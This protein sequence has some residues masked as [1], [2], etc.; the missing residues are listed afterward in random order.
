MALSGSGQNL[1]SAITG[2]DYSNLNS[3]YGYN[4]SSSGENYSDS[5]SNY[6]SVNP[7]YKDTVKNTAPVADYD[8]YANGVPQSIIDAENEINNK[9][10]PN[11]DYAKQVQDT[12]IQD[13]LGYLSDPNYK[14]TYTALQASQAFEYLSE[15]NKGAN[16]AN[17]ATPPAD[18]QLFTEIVPLWDAARNI[19][20]K[21]VE[22]Q[23]SPLPTEE[24]SIVQRAYNNQNLNATQRDILD[25][26]QIEHGD[27][28]LLNFWDKAKALLVPSS[29]IEETMDNAPSWAKYIQNIFPSIMAGG[30]G[31]AVG[32]IFGPAGAAIGGGVVGGL[33]Y[34]QGVTNVE[35]PVI[36][37]LLEGMDILSVW[38]E[39]GQGAI[40][41][42]AKGA[43]DK[44]MEDGQF[45]LLE[46]GK[47][48]GN[49]LQEFPDLWEV[50][51]FSYEIGAD[52]GFDNLLNTGRNVVAGA[53]DALFGTELGQRDINTV[54]RA[55]LGIG[56]LIDVDP[57]SRGYDALLN[58]YLPVYR[59]LRDEAVN[60]GMTYDQAKEFSLGH[61]SELL[62][63][64]MG[65]T[66]LANDFAVS[67]V[68]DPLNLAPFIQAKAAEFIGNKTGDT[69][70]S[71]AAKAALKNSSP[72]VDA[73]SVPVIQPIVEFVTG[74]NATQGMDTI[75]RVWAQEL[76]TKP[77]DTLSGFQRRIA[78]IDD[79]GLIKN[80]NQETN[81]LKRFFGQTEESKMYQISENTVS[82]LGSLLFDTDADPA[83]IPE[84]MREFA[85]LSEIPDDSPLAQ[86]RNSGLLNTMQ[87]TFSEITF[88]DIDKIQKGIDTYRQFASN[89]TAVDTVAQKLNMSIDDIFDA[90]DDTDK[91]S[92]LYLK[93]INE[94][95]TYMDG[96][97]LVWS[98][99]QVC[100][101]IDVFSSDQL[102]RRQY[103]LTMLKADIMEMFNKKSDDALFKRY[104]IEPDM[105]YNRLGELTKSV[106][107]IAL[108]NFSPSYFVNN[109]LN[110]LITR[111]VTG[112][113][114]V[115]SDEVK[116]ANAKRGLFYSREG[117]P[118]YEKT[119]DRITS[120]KHKDDIIGKAQ[121][122]WSNL[123]SEEKLSGKILKGLSNIDIEST[124]TRNAFEIGA[125]R[126]WSATWQPGLNI[127]EIPLELQALGITPE[128]NNTIYKAA[129]DSNSYSEFRQKLMG[130]VILP[131]AMSTL[132]DTISKRY[133]DK[134]G[135]LTRNLVDSNPW[136]T[137]RVS[138]LLETGNPDVIRSGFDDIIQEFTN[139]V[140]LQNIAQLETQFEDLCNRFAS[141]GLSAV[142]EMRQ[143][144]DDLYGDIWIDQTKESADLF[145]KRVTEGLW[146]EEE[147]RPLYESRMTMNNA[148]YQM[149]RKYE[150]QYLAAM[151]TGLGLTDD[152]AKNLVIDKLKQ[153]DIE[154]QYIN[155][156]HQLFMK[157]A[158]KNSPDYDYEY[159]KNSKL[160]MLQKVLDGKLEAAKD[161]DAIIVQHLR[162]T[163]SFTY[164]TQ[165][166]EF[167]SRLQ[168]IQRKKAELNQRE[169]NWLSDRLNNS[170]RIEVE[171]IEY[172]NSALRQIYKNDI[173]IAQREA[174]AMLS[175]LEDG[176]V[177]KIDEKIKLDVAQTLGI[178]L[179]YR[180]AKTDVDNYSDFL[181][182]YT[183]KSDPNTVL[184]KADFSNTTM[185]GTFVE[186]AA[187][188][189]DPQTLEELKKRYNDGDAVPLGA[190]DVKNET[191]PGE[192]VGTEYTAA[193]SE[194]IG[195]EYSPVKPNFDQSEAKLSMVRTQPFYYDTHLVKAGVYNEEK[196]IA[197]ITSDM[198]DT[199][200]TSGYTFPVIGIDVENPE[201][202]WV[203]VKDEPI[204]VTPGQPN[205][206]VYSM[207]AQN[208]EHPMRYGTTPATEPWGMAAW[209]TSLPLRELL[210]YWKDESL[211][212][213][214][215]STQN[216]SFFGNLTPEQQDAVYKWADSKLNPA[217]NYQRFASQRYGN[218]MVDLSLLN[219]NDRRGFDSTLTTIMPYQYWI[220]R[221]VM[222]WGARMIDQPKWF[223]MYARLEKEIEKNKRDFLPTRLEGMIG[224][225]LPYMPEGLG[226]GLFFNPFDIALPQK[227]FY[228]MTEY[229]DRNLHTIHENTISIID[230][231]YKNAKPYNGHII[232]K[233]E[234]DEAMK[235]SGDL[236]NQ[237]FTDQR[238][239]DETNTGLS[240]LVGSLINPNVLISSAWKALETKNGKDISYSPM[241]KMGNTLRA[242]ARD[243]AM[244]GVFGLMA[245]ALQLPEKT[246]RSMLGVESDPIGS[247][248]ADYW[249][250]KY[251]SDML[252]TKEH[253]HNEVYNAIAERD[254]N[255]LW[256]EARDRYSTSEAYKQQGGA[257]LNEIMQS[258][259]GNKPTSFGNMAGT[260]IASLFGGRTYSS[261]EEDYRRMQDLYRQIKDDP[262]MYS[263]FWNQLPDYKAGGYAY[264][265]NPTEMLHTILVDNCNNA[266]YALPETQK[267]AVREAFGGQFKE[268]FLNRSTDNIPDKTLI[269]WTRAMEGNVPNI[270]NDAIYQPM[271]QAFQVQWYA[272]STQ[273]LYDRYLNEKKQR[274]P[275]IDT[276]EQGY[277]SSAIQ[278]QYKALHPELQ[279]YWDW[280]ESIGMANPA[281]GT[282]LKRH[283]ANNSVASGKYDSITEAVKAQV[284]N[285]TR[286][287]LKNH[288]EK[289]WSMPPSAEHQLKIAYT[290]L[291]ISIP[292]ET[293]IKEIKW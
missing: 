96:S 64:Y 187:K 274:F 195:T 38:F 170:D 240:G 275:G 3:N 79:N 181:N 109:W 59:A 70:L 133:D 92:Q 119:G 125:N 50:G 89:R 268:L 127:P 179:L 68:A 156:E 87:S 97:G 265:D 113:G 58:T 162:D 135:K 281:L 28:R 292:Y 239:S 271:Q 57:N 69:A 177:W 86:Y 258:M 123:T 14:G 139:N 146:N 202:V 293:W 152:V 66:G 153:F 215:K 72:I 24:Q 284:N 145:R 253:T 9:S 98:P 214:Y 84:L 131:G 246:W 251:L 263:E 196:L 111:S 237:I 279:Q 259:A 126:Y 22:Q 210:N 94:N 105:W 288:I 183:D 193:N 277:Y 7:N 166:N 266:Y 120:K 128:M 73:L 25:A 4:S 216:G 149:A 201:A 155:E 168:D 42:T 225:P 218:T 138:S 147:F 27:W 10:I 176:R 81:P 256:Q 260:A 163:L 164:E 29:N 198:P 63:N 200:S 82:L 45:D 252:Y 48:V 23:S 151:I 142:S 208:G 6:N 37:E 75:R 118:M 290:N 83:A 231:Y 172:G 245:N 241:Y 85:G 141:E 41:A 122:V 227:Q 136:I 17:W 261:G 99:Q 19:Q 175:E 60:Q 174:N 110:N 18:D 77:V 11:P 130:D 269:E 270:A 235:G 103:S 280:K 39:Q 8:P 148:D 143:M 88:E 206:V 224:I 21:A 134:T 49:M 238:N 100:D 184:N 13:N 158:D 286:A 282:Y 182:H 255:P 31:A 104:N 51:Q 161:Y 116:T 112:V 229:F 115:L 242:S 222:N 173:Q 44:T 47:E 273:G 76:Q 140:N 12:I 36:N 43:W 199:I 285:Y 165:I 287:C 117:N 67:S 15:R 167:E 78:N 106:Q 35:I 248:W 54:S 249:T 186:N 244:E 90:L 32:S 178:E 219:Y 171:E 234:Y 250:I 71:N 95:I 264:K 150:V 20:S 211:D 191:M 185:E 236:Y 114:G 190:V 223:S 129:M 221:S 46:L 61:M 267:E 257:I 34:L 180:E 102:G 160:E 74:K 1:A 108:L 272:D 278:D 169:M 159:Y 154:T 232:T 53:S 16:Y 283:T 55:N 197:Y 213:L 107:S 189:A 121:N 209:E 137:E 212:A 93:I 101:K 204:K 217:F 247:S 207:Y 91:R 192:R 254:N 228:N 188:N 62:T 132:S 2:G 26:D 40:G 80:F 52:F 5:G 124:E 30:G 233:Q 289:G 157:Y 276:I 194:N 33:T 56:G 220:T 262:Q 226:Q 203:Y 230:E 291:G 205:D 144:L 243:T 65:T